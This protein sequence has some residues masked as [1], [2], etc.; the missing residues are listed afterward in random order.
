MKAMRNVSLKFERHKSQGSAADSKFEKP[1]SSNFNLFHIPSY[2]F[3]NALFFT[4]TP[5][6]S[7]HYMGTSYSSVRSQ[8]N[9]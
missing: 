3:L 9:F 2:S 5:D 4:I 1:T 6:L 7:P 8:Q